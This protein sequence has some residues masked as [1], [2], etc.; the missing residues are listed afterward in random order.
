MTLAEMQAKLI[1]HAEKARALQAQAEARDLTNEEAQQVDEAL[2]TVEKLQAAITRAE[3]VQALGKPQPKSTPGVGPAPAPAR[4]F[5]DHNE[6]F[7]AVAFAAIRNQVDPRLLVNT[8]GDLQQESSGADGGYLL[9]VDKRSLQS[10]L[11]PP[12]SIAGRCDPILT[13]SNAVTFPIDDD[14]VWSSSMGSADV[15]EG[16]TLTETKA[17]FKTLTTTLVKK[18]VLVRV[19]SEMLED[20]TN[21]GAYVLNKTAQK[22]RW[23][24]DKAAFAAFKASGAL[25]TLTGT[26]GTY[27][28][29]TAP[30]NPKLAGVQKMWTS[31]IPEMRA[32]AVWLV[33]PQFETVLQGYAVG[34]QPVYIPQGGIS[35]AP[36]ASLYGRPVIFSELSDALNVAGDIMLA[37]PQSFFLAMKSA[38][39]RTDVSI[40][41][42]FA[43]DVV[44]YR[45]YVRAVAASKFSALI[46][47]GDGSS[48][49]G[50]AVVLAANS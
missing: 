36:F 22:L 40:H 21:I 2:A 14:P 45:S 7:R 20:G 28:E 8:A 48:T 50:N 30:Q 37:D 24:I 19:T 29:A 38:G 16:G 39:P 32:T 35:Q 23:A 1:E 49:A 33:N 42:E 12:E 11:T 27:R 31:M 44:G 34:N 43:K 46:T 5:A 6:F 47:R 17:Q 3:R 25:K 15:A 10:L 9:P 13:G 18:G 41:S 26:A 4:G